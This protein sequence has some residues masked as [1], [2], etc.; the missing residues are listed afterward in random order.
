MVGGGGS[1]AVGSTCGT[2]LQFKIDFFPLANNL[3]GQKSFIL[4]DIFSENIF[5][6]PS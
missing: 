1:E 6:N 3:I 4:F 2:G 5:Q